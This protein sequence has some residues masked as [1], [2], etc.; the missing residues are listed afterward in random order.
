MLPRAVRQSLFAWMVIAVPISAAVAAEGPYQATGFKIGEVTDRSAIVW[1]RLTLRPEPNPPDAPM[2]QFRY[3]EQPEQRRAK[4]RKRQRVI[5]V[6]YPDGLTVADIRHAAPGSAGQVRVRYRPEGAN[7]WEQTEWAD[8]NPERDFTHQFELT[9]L[10][11]N[12]R[13]E[14]QVEGR[15]SANAELGQ[16]RIGRFRTAPAPDQP[17][18]VVFTVSTGQGFGDQDRPDGFNI[19]PE[20]LK[21]DPS[22]FVHTGDI[23]YYDKLAKTIEL[24]RYHWQRTY[25]RPTNV[26]FHCQVASYFIKDDHDTWQNDCWPSMKND[27][28]F[29]FTFQQGLAVFR[30]QVPMGRGPTYRTYRWGKDLQVWLVE[31]RD[32]R[33]P[34]PMPDGPEKTIWGK[35]QKEWF[36]RTV[37]QSDATFRILISPTPLVGPDRDSKHDNHANK[38]FAHEGNELRRFIGRQKNMVVICGDRHWQYMS[39]DPATGVREYSCGPASDQHAGGWRNS[40]FRPDRHRYLQVIGGFLSVT[41][42]RIDGEPMMAVR[43]HNVHGKVQFTDWVRAAD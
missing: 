6:V 43:F 37:Q 1:T 35:T 32:F 38:D 21:L 30:E 42:D 31:G 33:S 34:N 5:G 14:V 16:V 15:R 18:R 22:F 9:G 12:T 2:V 29:R 39:I 3:A 4:R 13:Y 8:V 25:S 7:R 23:V 40:D 19:Y 20:M 11:P 17:A 24:A 26:A 10:R 36:K 41:V 27:K 28:M